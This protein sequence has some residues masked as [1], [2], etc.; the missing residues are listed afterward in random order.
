MF[1]FDKNGKQSNYKFYVVRVSSKSVEKLL[2][3]MYDVKSSSRMKRYGDE[4]MY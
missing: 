3:L 2:L 1:S 4:K